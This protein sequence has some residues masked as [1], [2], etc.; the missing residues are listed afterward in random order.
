MGE[1]TIL[2]TTDFSDL[3][4]RAIAE[5]VKLAR[6]AGAKIILFYAVEDTLPPLFYGPEPVISREEVLKRH[7]SK[8]KEALID[9][10]KEIPDELFLKPKV[11]VGDARYSIVEAAKEE[12]VE[13]IVMATHGHSAFGA[14]LLGSTTHYVVNKA[15]CPVVV[16]P[17][18][19]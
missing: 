16:V 7:E 13:Y 8:A 18:R 4:K 9:L 5:A 19:K 6:Y 10:A 3:S 17:A 15:P 14:F 11:S 1:K 2:V 12:N